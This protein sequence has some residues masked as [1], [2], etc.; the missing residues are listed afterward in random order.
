MSANGDSDLPPG[1]YVKIS[2]S[3]TGPGIDPDIFDR[4]FDPYFTTKDV[5]K[6]S[7]LGLSVVHGIVKN[8]NGSIAVDSEPGK[9]AVFSILLPKIDAQP[10]IKPER[11]MDLST[12]NETLLFVDDEPS[13]MK[14]GQRMMER[15]GYKIDATISPTDALEWFR[16]SPDKY[17]LIITDMTMPQMTGVSLAEELMRIRP[18]I[19]VIICTGHSSLIDE[20]K[21]KTLDI[22]AFVM[23]P[24]TRQKIA[25]II[26]Q[27]LDN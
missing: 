21:S 25:K 23:K 20:E 14:L 24:M 17:D 9:G 15:L 8:H 7:G 26:R 13:L 19:P 16:L 22:A 3:D 2:V 12:G 11:S 27:V 4:I 1:A 18:D 6:G 5:G 10:E